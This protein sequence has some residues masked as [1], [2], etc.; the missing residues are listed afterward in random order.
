MAMI[1][2]YIQ[3]DI[4]D[5]NN[6]ETYD[7]YEKCWPFKIRLYNVITNGTKYIVKIVSK[8]TKMNICRLID[9]G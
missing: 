5:K 6:I 9:W 8:Y 1:I 2:I 4:F 3:Q 7:I